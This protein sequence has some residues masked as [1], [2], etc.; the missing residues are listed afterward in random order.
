MKEVFNPIYL[1][2]WVNIRGDEYAPSNSELQPRVMQPQATSRNDPI[3]SSRT[4]PDS[5]VTFV[6]SYPRGEANRAPK[7]HFD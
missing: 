6:T 5:S 1:G 7:L 3:P 2:R 4:I